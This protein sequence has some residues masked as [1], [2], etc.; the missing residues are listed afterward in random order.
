MEIH[1]QLVRIHRL[2]NFYLIKILIVMLENKYN[3]IQELLKI[4]IK[5]IFKLIIMGNC[6]N[7]I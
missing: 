1:I 4:L 7:L 6:I 2:N 5:N 3:R